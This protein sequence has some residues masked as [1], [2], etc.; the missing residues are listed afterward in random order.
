MNRNRSRRGNYSMIMG[1]AITAMLGFAAISVDISYVRLAQSQAQD[2]ADAASQAGLIVLKSTG[3]DEDE[4]LNAAQE[5]VGLNRI[6]GGAP[7]LQSLDFGYWDVNDSSA[8]FDGT[9]DHPNAVRANVA[10]SG[11]GIPMLFGPFFGWNTVGVTQSAVSATRSLQVV[12]SM[13]ITGSWHQ[14]N[15]KNARLAAL[16]F[17]AVVAEGPH[18]DD[19]VGMNIWT[20]RYGWEYTPFTH[21]ADETAMA[22]VR[23][24]WGK[25]NVASKAGKFQPTWVGLASKSLPCTLNASPNQNNFTVGTPGG[26]YPDMPR[27]YT[28]EPGTDHTVGV[29][30][31]RRMFQG[32]YD[33]TA[34]RALLVLT[35]GQPNGLSTNTIRGTAGYAEKRWSEFIGPVPRT[36]ATVK[37]ESQTMAAALYNDLDVNIWVVSFVT[38]DPFMAGMA[39]GDGTYQV[40]SSSAALISIFRSIAESMPLAVVE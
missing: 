30:L 33:P 8:T 16:E 32:A 20:M 29:G 38:G 36:T 26:C 28:D 6:V 18:E 34:Y 35:D 3:G 1:L 23:T 5:V 4:A 7:T 15:F 31:S 10:S 17:L 39:K 14:N 22:G 25:L 12:L 24:Q 2:V 13:D 27:E 9:A 19:V 40:T 37:A 21:L 11:A